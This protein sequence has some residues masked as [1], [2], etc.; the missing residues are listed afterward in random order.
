MRQLEKKQGVV[1]LLREPPWYISLK[2]NAAKGG[3]PLG[4]SDFRVSFLDELDR[5]GFHGLHDLLYS[6]MKRLM[7]LQ[8]KK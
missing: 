4:F 5:E 1:Q 7:E 6:S 8:K 3:I 2:Q